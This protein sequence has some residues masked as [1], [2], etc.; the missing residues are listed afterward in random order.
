MIFA[1]GNQPKFCTQ[2]ESSEL[3]IPSSV[4]ICRQETNYGHG[5]VSKQV[6]FQTY[7]LR[8]SNRRDPPDISKWVRDAATAPVALVLRLEDSG[9]AML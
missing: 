5:E 1:L 2:L 3:Q 6:D 8:R 7:L 9:R 4:A